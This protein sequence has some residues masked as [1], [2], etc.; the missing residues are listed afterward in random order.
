MTDPRRA[1]TVKVYL[2][3]AEMAAL[4]KAA[5]ALGWPVSVFIRTAALDQAH[6]METDVPWV[7]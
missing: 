2:S 1:V 6:E 4:K 5:R 3:D 7:K